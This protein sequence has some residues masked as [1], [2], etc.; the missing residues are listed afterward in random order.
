MNINCKKL[1]DKNLKIGSLKKELKNLFYNKIKLNLK[2]K[3][4]IIIFFG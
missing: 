4:N 1:F 3:I 2:C